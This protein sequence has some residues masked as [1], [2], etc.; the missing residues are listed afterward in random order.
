M[1]ETDKYKHRRTVSIKQV[2]AWLLKLQEPRQNM[3]SGSGEDWN[4]A[5]IELAF[6]DT[7]LS[8]VHTI[9]RLGELNNE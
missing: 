8:K 9:G 6:I 7:L 2:E 1:K 4:K 3:T 5:D